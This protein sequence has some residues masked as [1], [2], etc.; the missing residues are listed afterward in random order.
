[1][2]FVL[3]ASE[4]DTVVGTQFFRVTGL[5]DPPTRLLRPAFLCRVAAVN[6]RRRQ[7]SSRS[8]PAAVDR[9]DGSALPEMSLE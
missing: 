7:R 6:L 5:L 2:D 3:T 1:V 8:G 4:S 9:A